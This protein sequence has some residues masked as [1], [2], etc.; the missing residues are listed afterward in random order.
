VSAH[1]AIASLI[2]FATAIIKAVGLDSGPKWLDEPDALFQV[3]NW[4]VVSL[5]IGIEAATGFALLFVPGRLP[6]IALRSLTG[7]FAVYHTLRV[8]IGFKEPCSCLGRLSDW[9]PFFRDHADGLTLLI[10][11]VLAWLSSFEG[12][13]QNEPTPGPGPNRS[14]VVPILATCGLWVAFGAFV[15]FI[16]GE[17]RLGGDEGMELGKLTFL[18]DQSRIASAWND[19][20]WAFSFFLQGLAYIDPGI[21]FLRLGCL[22][23]T[24]P[25]PLVVGLLCARNGRPWAA[26]LFP[27]LV[28]SQGGAAQLIP[29]VMMEG[30]AVGLGTAAAIP[31]LLPGPITSVRCWIS[32][33]IAALAVSFKATA[34][35]AL[36]PVLVIAFQAGVLRTFGIACIVSGSLC[37]AGSIFGGLVRPEIFTESHSAKPPHAIAWDAWGT[38]F[39]LLLICSVVALWFRASLAWVC[40]LLFAATVL[41]LHQPAWSYYHIHFWI[42]AA[43]LAVMTIRSWI[44]GGIIGLVCVVFAAHQI[45]ILRGMGTPLGGNAAAFTQSIREAK[46]AS[47]YSLDPAMHYLTGVPPHPDL[48][49]LPLKRTW[50][51]YSQAHFSNDLLRIRPQVMVL[52]A[53]QLRQISTNGYNLLG[54]RAG[55][56]LLALPEAGILP[57]PPEPTILQR[58]GL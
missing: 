40:G 26:L 31:L 56:V 12:P 1:R 10:L 34:A 36:V 22:A 18:Q 28:L 7:I 13:P 51:G 47:M 49:V 27:L 16:A 5:A 58:I 43:G 50:A 19:Q 38:G 42:P 39:G 3:P 46:P 54:T 15:I 11:L 44:V 41:S 25:I 32:G 2:L 35:F 14:P 24:L 37:L 45:Q 55:S 20:S 8:L 4:A 9:S 21:G 52:S 23:L 48:A 6:I 33:L 53:E 29:S 57:L 30:P 17:N